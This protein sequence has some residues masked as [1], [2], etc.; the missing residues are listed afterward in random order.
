M[1]RGISEEHVPFLSA[2]RFM[3][4]REASSLVLLLRQKKAREQ[5]FDVDEEVKT[6]SR[7]GKL[8]HKI[9]CTMN[10]KIK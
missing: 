1:Q 7:L 6:L 10:K 2:R 5:D 3:D 4:F 8:L 9:R